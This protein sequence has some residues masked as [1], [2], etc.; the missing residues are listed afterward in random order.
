MDQKH[1]LSGFVELT[2]CD[3]K[4]RGKKDMERLNMSEI[5]IK[6][7]SVLQIFFLNICSRPWLPLTLISKQNP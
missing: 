4:N 5:E 6:G 3:V 2:F 7:I 1:I